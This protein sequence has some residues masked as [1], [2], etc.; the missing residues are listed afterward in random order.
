MLVAGVAAGYTLV[1]TFARTAYAAALI[2]MTVAA[3]GQAIAAT[4]SRGSRIAAAVLPMFLL[5]IVGGM[6]LLSALD[7]TY[8]EQRIGDLASGFNAREANWFGGLAWRDDTVLASLVG[9][10]LGTYPRVSLA[11]SPPI[12]AP[13]NFVVKH[14]NGAT[15]LSLTAGSP[16]YFQQIVAVEPN[17]S[18]RLLLRFRAPDGK[19]NLGAL[20]CEKMLLYSDNCSVGQQDA[21]VGTAW[22]NVTFTF[23]TTGLDRKAVLGW[24]RRPVVLSLAD[25]VPG[26]TIE[27]GNVRLIDP[28]GRDVL[29]NG[30]FAAGTERWYF[31]SDYHS[32]WRIFNQYL[33][34]LFEGGALGLIAF[35][36]L[37]AAAL[38]GALSAARTGDF[39]AV[40]VAASL[41]AFLVSSGFDN[42]LEAPRLA[43]IFYL[44]ALLGIA[45]LS[46]P[47]RTP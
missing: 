43:T 21:Q 41:I 5:V 9:M 36:V 22:Q 47:A 40:P 29:M 33:M 1:V 3:L 46:P 32:A 15:Y 13:P 20:L 27:F 45:G 7:A 34:M 38:L 4:R 35:I 25:G 24:V 44:V 16:F 26:S 17:Q 10:G 19:A 30:D 6:V 31:T 39:A 23:S 18:Y 11:H 42:L 8:M 12:L 14:E 37:V 2:G 28:H